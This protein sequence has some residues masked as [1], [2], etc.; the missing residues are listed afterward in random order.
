MED[1]GFNSV[2]FAA[3]F[4]KNSENAK[5]SEPGDLTADELGLVWNS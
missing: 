4:L 2:I 1:R 5:I 3:M